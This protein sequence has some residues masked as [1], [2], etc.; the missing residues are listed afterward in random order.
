MLWTVGVKKTVWLFFLQ[1]LAFLEAVRTPHILSDWCLVFF[2]ILLKDV[3]RLSIQCLVYF[4]KLDLVTHISQTQD[5]FNSIVVNV[6]FDNVQTCYLALIYHKLIRFI[7]MPSFKWKSCYDKGRKY[8]SDWEK[9]FLWLKKASDGSPDAYR[10]LCHTT[11]IPRH[12]NLINHEKNEK[13]KKRVPKLCHTTMIPRHSN[14]INHEKNEKHKKRVPPT[15]QT[16]FKGFTSNSKSDA[17][18][19]HAF[20]IAVTITCHSAVHSVDH[21]GEIMVTHG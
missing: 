3:I 7:G 16:A 10:K 9:T 8:N 11:M 17:L 5:L 14:L 18:K 1:Y 21:L 13:H 2:N 20:Q 12:S 19:V 15:G 4:L 6:I